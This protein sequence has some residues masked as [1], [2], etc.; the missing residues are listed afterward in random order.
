M[1]DWLEEQ[2]AGVQIT[3]LTI[4][5]IAVILFGAIMERRYN[6]LKEVSK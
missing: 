6:F 1:M 4:P 3:I 2:N 5:L